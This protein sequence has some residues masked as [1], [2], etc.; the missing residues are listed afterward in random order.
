MM[1]RFTG[2]VA[3]VMTSSMSSVKLFCLCAILL[4]TVALS[5][6]SHDN[7]LTSSVARS[8][9]ESMVKERYSKE[10]D[11]TQYIQYTLSQTAQIPTN[12]IFSVLNT[13]TAEGAM[14]ATKTTLLSKKLKLEL[15]SMLTLISNTSIKKNSSKSTIDNE[16]DYY[17]CL[18]KC[19]CQLLEN[20]SRHVRVQCT[21]QQ[22]H[23]EAKFDALKRNIFPSILIIR[24]DPY[25]LI[26]SK[27]YP[28]M[29]RGLHTFIG[30]A[31]INCYFDYVPQ[32]TFY[33]MINLKELYI[34]NAS[35]ITFHTAAFETLKSLEA[36]SIV[37]SEMSS[38]PSLCHLKNLRFVN[39]TDNNIG[40]LDRTGLICNA[41][42]QNL[43]VIELS[44]NNLRKIAI[45]ISDI[46]DNLKYFC[47]S[48]N[49]IEQISEYSFRGLYSLRSL[50]IGSNLIA[51]LSSYIFQ[52]ISA[53][54]SL[55][56]S[57]NKMSS[58]SSGILSHLRNLTVLHLSDLSLNMS[59]FNEIRKLKYLKVLDLKNNCIENMEMSGFRLFSL[60][61]YLDLSNNY[62]RTLPNNIFMSL[63]NLEV[64]YM[65]KNLIKKIDKDAFSGLSKLKILALQHNKIRNLHIECLQQLLSLIVIN[66]S[67]NDIDHLPSFQGLQNLLVLD[68]MHNNI[69]QLDGL[70]FAGVSGIRAINL[71]NNRIKTIGTGTFRNLSDLYAIWIENNEIDF[72][73][74]SAFGDS[75]IKELY[76][77]KNN[78]SDINAFRYSNLIYLRKLDLSYNN[79]LHISSDSFSTFK[80]IETLNISNN[81][82]QR[83]YSR[84]FEPLPKLRYLDLSY[85]KIR[86]LQKSALTSSTIF[87]SLKLQGNPI[88]CDCNMQWVKRWL[89]SS[90]TNG[91]FITD[92]DMLTCSVFDGTN[93]SLLSLLNTEYLVCQYER[94]CNILKC[95]CCDV[96]ECSCSYPCPDKC[97][98]FW[99]DDKSVN[100]VRCEGIGVDEFPKE[101]PPA[102]TRVYLDRNNI[103][104]VSRHFFTNMTQLEHL[105]MN[106]SNIHTIEDNA[107]A[108]L[109]SLKTLHLNGNYISTIFSKT[110]FGLNN[111]QQ[112]L[113]SSNRITFIDPGS[114]SHF[115]AKYQLDLSNNLLRKVD[116]FVLYEMSL[117]SLLELSGNPWT[118]DCKF[119]IDFASFI[120]S[121][122]KKLID[123]SALTCTT[124]TTS[125]FNTTILLANT[126][127][128]DLCP[129]ITV[130]HTKAV[131][132]NETLV[133]TLTT[134]LGAFV[135][136]V[137]IVFVVLWNRD[138]LKIWIYAKFGFRFNHRVL[139]SADV[140][141]RY[142][143][144]VSYSS[145]DDDFVLNKL[146]PVLENI[147]NYRL[148]VHNRD[149]NVGAAIADNIVYS[150]ES[151]KRVIVVLSNNFVE[152][153]WCHYEFR[154]AHHTLLLEKK[155]RI[156]MILLDKID[157][158]KLVPELQEYI[159]KNTYLNQ[160]DDW[161]WENIL[162][163]MP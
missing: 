85:N 84:T 148:C 149:F 138:F 51:S 125:C 66:L 135:I 99:S 59:I 120:Y 39:F 150:V 86:Y 41:R 134:L 70:T 145:K 144:F 123:I 136:I 11:E 28:F 112:L 122:V 79:V 96:D 53:L 13:N 91:M 73:E 142:D 63:K 50:N 130:H 49:K 5:S 19:T 71:S 36:L 22:I 67:Y 90:D 107:F 64:L 78:I 128:L 8:I 162:Y 23:D 38:V 106:E 109:S 12:R 155:N 146:V 94:D 37:Q 157:Q 24:C 151:S 105:S 69:K 108:T 56:L 131:I 101:I 158:S 75:R 1:L 147:F 161:F 81:K 54:N 9:T 121:N 104:V 2:A 35:N 14:G 153:E 47:A 26:K 6:G 16:P 156:I 30:L 42:F 133:S 127:I 65:S 152:S 58:F 18:P 117:A 98:C 48:G 25:T 103:S 88:I 140:N 115:P 159:K 68:L 118:C 57:K 60:L 89:L 52:D 32:K 163:A 10:T 114:F 124:N 87:T 92:L 132:H 95:S 76:L 111:L 126:S 34:K 129:S 143:A 116:R 137:I 93:N 82:I 33:G 4:K 119:L 74:Y 62:I 113:L 45:N 43:Q 46:S 80:S 20:P 7:V 40:T 55:V 77:R 15:P 27:L 83:I 102:V 3:L 97:V 72:I 17:V 31:I 29:F 139:D 141:K 44:K 61:I 110:L 100:S 21:I 154:I 160:D